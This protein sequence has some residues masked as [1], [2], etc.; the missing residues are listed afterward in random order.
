MALSLREKQSAFAIAVAKLILQA[1][2]LGYG[3]TL[4]EAWRSGPEAARLAKASKG[5]LNSLHCQRLAIDLNLFKDGTF[6][7]KT[8]DY[9]PLG[10]WWEAQN[11]ITSDI[12]YCWGGRFNDGDHFSFR[13]GGR[14]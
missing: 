4:G 7:Q 3:V 1:E 8:E 12:D 14:Q 5:I 10:E 11:L 6:L 2:K 9:L 13:H